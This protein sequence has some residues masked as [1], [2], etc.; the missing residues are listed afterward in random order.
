MVIRYVSL[1]SNLVKVKIIFHPVRIRSCKARCVS[2]DDV[3]NANVV[4]VYKQLILSAVS[5]WI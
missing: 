1:Y 5:F 4:N 3:R 2:K